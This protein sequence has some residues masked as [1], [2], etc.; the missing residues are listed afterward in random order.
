MVGLTRIMAFAQ[1]FFGFSSFL[2]GVIQTH[3]R[4]LI[5]ALSPVLYNVG[6]IIGILAFGKTLGIYGAAV[7][8][9]IGACLPSLSPA[10]SRPQTWF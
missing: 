7:G 4:F 3:K 2:T 5:P 9:V 10:P 8:V 1:L 6:I